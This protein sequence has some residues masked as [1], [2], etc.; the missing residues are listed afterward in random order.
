MTENNV[1][2]ASRDRHML[3]SAMVDVSH[4]RAF[5][6][7]RT[8]PKKGYRRMSVTTKTSVPRGGTDSLSELL[9]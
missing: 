9:S 1:F 2:K 7:T 8:A 4:E 5:C 3:T 6:P